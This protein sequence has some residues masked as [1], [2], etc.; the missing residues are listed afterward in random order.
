MVGMTDINRNYLP[1][2]SYGVIG[3]CHSALLVAPDGSVDWGCLPDFDSPAIFCR[4]LDHEHGGYFQISPTEPIPGTQRYLRGSNVLQTRFTSTSGEMVLT[5]FMPVE[6]LRAWPYQGMNNNSWT[7]EDGSCH[8]LVRIVEC[9]HGEMSISMTLKVSPNYAASPSEV[10]LVPGNKGILVSGGDQHVGLAIIGADILPS[11][12]VNVVQ[13]QEARHPSV[14]LTVTLYEGERLLFALGMG[15]NAQATRRL[16]EGELHRRNFDAEL[17]HTLHC[18]REWVSICNYRGPYQEWVERSALALKMMTYAPTGAIVAAPTTSL[19]EHIGGVRNWDYR[20]TWLRDATFTLY[21]LNVLG[22]TDEARAFTHWLHRLTHADGESIQIMYGIRGERD[23]TEME[24][25][26]LDGYCGSRPVR[27]GNG[28]AK[29]KQMDVFGE[30]LDCIHLYRRQGGFE[31]YGETLDGPL[32][33]LMCELVEHVCA[34]WQDPDS[35]IWEVRGEDRHYVYSKVMCWVALDRGIRAAQQLNLEADL[36]RWLLVRDQ[37]RADILANGYDTNIGAFT[38]SYGDTALDGANLLLPLV[39]FI[40]PDDPRMR[41]TID[42]MMEQL[43]DENGFVYRYI[44][45]DG[46]EGHE[47][48]FTICTFW[49]VD[50]LAM[51]GRVDE[52]RSLFERLLSY[53]GRLGLFSEEVDTD[54]RGALGNYPQAFTHIALIN[55]AFNL[56]KAEI[57]MSEHHTDPV[58]AAIRLQ[59]Q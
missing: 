24:L 3:D 14:T 22:F 1:I 35:G 50:N 54:S 48:T 30:V 10:S 17:A 13:D 37:I 56:R 5:D 40:P 33:T 19:P 53:A 38:Q 51:Q 8:C 15:R 23:L 39:G 21:A 6:T 2:N 25:S 11:V 9:T 20:F 55:S 59:K 18:W 36:P 46:L 58:I 7:R 26:H 31:R 29:Q 32:W 16:V 12:T 57:R 45:E 41:S 34:H 52:A 28:A 42:R 4:L 43:T 47:G 27:V 49:L 44:S